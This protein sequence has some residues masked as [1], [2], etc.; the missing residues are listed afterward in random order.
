MARILLISFLLQMERHDKSDA[1]QADPLELAGRHPE[2]SARGPLST[3]QRRIA[4]GVAILLALDVATHPMPTLRALV[5]DATVFYL[6]SIAYRLA[7]AWASRKGGLSFP[8]EVL[9]EQRDWPLYSILV[10]MYREGATLPG[11]VAAL[12]RLD[13]PADRLDVQLLL[14]A[15]DDETVSAAKAMDLPSFVRVTLVPPSLPRTKPKACNIG[16]AAAKGDYLVIYDAEDRPDPDQLKKAVLAFE[17]SG[18]DVACVQS[19][20]DYHNPRQNLLTRLF[21]AEYSA[22]FDLALPGLARL[23]APIPLGGTSNHFRIGVLRSLLGWDAYNVTEDCDLGVRLARAGYRTLMLDA[24]T[25]EEACSS[26]PYWI[27]QRTRWQK[28][29]IQT[30]LVHTRHPLALVRD[31][32]V[33][34]TI[35]FLLLVGGSIF[36]SL[37]NPVFWLMTLAWFLL[38]SRGIEALYPAPVF[39]ASAFCLF[40]GNFVFFYIG[41][42]GCYRRRHDRII[43]ANILM[44]FYWALMSV[45]AWRAL[46]QFLTDPF[47]WEKTK[48]GLGN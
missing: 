33:V 1:D 22:W 14:E 31:L 20:L 5:A 16:L 39:A 46:A 18:K 29:Y 37:A 26:L 43:L 40:V 34:N 13:Y 45:S 9:A 25:W 35:H 8:K 36:S 47:R 41:L 17:A 42:A 32:G 10:P 3:T 48:H 28:G 44:P 4:L 11:L 27:R 2:W 6:L 19:A 30:F 7:I 12:R 38:R 15:D 21:T 24:T 23:G